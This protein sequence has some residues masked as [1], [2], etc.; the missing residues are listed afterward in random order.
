MLFRKK[1]KFYISIIISLAIL[2]SIVAIPWNYSFAEN[3]TE[4]L[5]EVM[6]NTVEVETITEELSVIMTPQLSLL[7][8]TTN[9]ITINWNYVPNTLAYEVEFNGEI[10]EEGVFTIYTQINLAPNIEY[11]FRVRGKNSNQVGDWSEL[12][13][14]TTLSEE[15]LQEDIEYEEKEVEPEEKEVELEEKEVEPEEKEVDIEEKEI[16]E[17]D[18][19]HEN[20]EKK[21]NSIETPNIDAN[22]QLT[23]QAMT[24]MMSGNGTVENPF[25]ITTRQELNDVRNNSTAHYRLGNDIDLENQLWTPIGTATATFK[26]SLDGAGYKITNLKTNLPTTDNVGLFGCIENATIKNLEIQNVDIIGRTRVG[27]LVGYSRGISNILNNKITGQ[28]LV[29]GVGT[30]GQVGGLIG[31]MEN[32]LVDKCFSTAAVE[33][34]GI[35]SADAEIGGLIGVL[36][37]AT[38]RESYSTGDVKSNR[39]KY[40][41]GLVGRILSTNV[42]GQLIENSFSLSNISSGNNQA[43]S[44]IGGLVGGIIR[45]TGFHVTIRNSYSAG[46][47]SY[48]TMHIG[49]G[50]LVGILGNTLVENSYYDGV[51]A[52]YIP[53]KVSDVGRLTTVMKSRDNYK[54]WDFNGIWTIDEGVSYPYLRGI[55]KPI[56]VIE[57]LPENDVAGGRGTLD[58]PYIIQTKEQLHNV[59]YEPT[60]HYVLGN[61][62]DLENELWQPVGNI[63]APFNGTFDGRGYKISNLKIDRGNTENI[64]F[65]GVI[66]NTV[67]Q[68]LEIQNVIVIGG[69]R[70]GALVGYAKGSNNILT[71]KITGIG[72]VKGQIAQAGGLIGSMENG[73]VNRSY[74]EA[75]VELTNVAVSAEIGG[76]IGRLTG[77]TIRESYASGNI[78]INRGHNAGGLI[79][80]ITSVNLAGQR[81][82]NSYSLGN[83]EIRDLVYSYY[84][85]GLIGSISRSTGY[86]VTIRNCY[87]SGIIFHSQVTAVGGIV[88]S[89]GNTI[90]ENSY[91]NGVSSRFIPDKASDV[92]RLTTAMKRRDNYN[93]WDF[94]SIW[95]IDE[96]MSYPY[97]RSLD[98]PIKVTEGLPENDV[99][100]GRGTLDNPYIIQTKEQLH[101][102]KYEPTGHYVLGN[103]IDLEN[104]LWQPVGNIGAPF[105]G[106]FDGRGYKIS[107]LKIDRGNTEN[108]G[109]FA[110]IENTVIKNLELN[111]VNVA[112]G[113][114]VGG[115]VGYSKGSNN[116]LDCKITGIGLVKGKIAQA[117]GLIGSMENGLV[118]RSYSEAAVELTNVSVT[119]EIGGLIGRLTGATIR[120]SYATGNVRI[121]IGQHAGGLIGNITSVN[122]AGQ[123]IENSYSLGNVQIDNL[124]ISYYIGGLVGSIS[125][126]A[127]YHVTI[128]NCYSA[129]RIDHNPVS[130][131]GGIVGSLGNTIME[132]SYYDGVST[133]FIPDKASDVARLTTTMKRRDNYNNWDFDSIWTIDEGMS[134]PYLRN[135]DKPIKVTEGLPI[136]DVAGGKG[137]LDNPYIIQT[138]GQLNSIKYEPTAHYVLGNDIDLENEVWHPIGNIGAPFKGTFDGRE[139]KVSNLRIERGS[140]DNTGFF[141]VIESSTVKNI[142]LENVNVTGGF[143]TGALVG[144]SKGTSN[145]LN[146]KVTG[147]GLIKG[148]G[149]KGQVGGLIGS[150]EKGQVYKS[151]STVS[152]E[153]IASS[154]VEVDIGGLIGAVAGATI[155]ESYS[156]GDVKINR[157]RYAGGL[158]GRIIQPDAVT[159]TLIE[160]S[161][162]LGDIYIQNSQPKSFFIGGL[163]GGGFPTIKNSYSAGRVTCDIET[164]RGGLIG[165]LG[166]STIENSYYDGILANYMPYY[167]TDIGRLTTAMTSRDNYTNWNFD[168]IWAIDEGASY[169]YL[170][171]LDKPTKVTEGLPE[172][173]VAGGRGT[174]D[175]PYILK[176]K[177]HLKNI[178]Y[179]PTAHYVLGNDIDLENELW[180]PIGNIGMPF[181][182]TFDGSGYKI[183]NLKIERGNVENIGLFAIIENAV[184]KNLEIEN[185]NVTGGTRVGGLVGY[186]RGSSNISN[187]KITGTSLI[188]AT[189]QTGQVGGLIGS[190]E[191]GLV[192]RSSSNAVVEATNVSTFAEIGGL[193]GTLT[194][195]T[196]RASYATGNVKSNRGRF[197]GGLIGT[198]NSVSIAG[199]RI[200]NCYALGNVQIGDSQIG[201]TFIG[202]LIGGITRSTG[203][204]VT[205]KNCYSSGTVA[206]SS[207]PSYIGGMVASLGNTVVEN[208]YFD[209][210]KTG[211]T[212]PLA[213]ARTTEELYQKQTFVGWD[214]D[215]I[216][217]IDEGAS[218]PYLDEI[219]LPPNLSTLQVSPNSI[220]LNWSRIEGVDGYQ[221]EVDGVVIDMVLDTTYTHQSLQ[222]GS[223]HEYRVRVIKN[224]VASDWSPKLV[225]ITP[226]PN[227]IVIT[228]TPSNNSILVEWNQFS[229]YTTY[230]I[231]LD[232]GTIVKVTGTSYTHTGLSANTQHYYRVRGIEPQPKSPWSGLATDIT[233]NG[234][235]SLAFAITD[236]PLDTGNEPVEVTI[237][238][239]GFEDIYTLHIDFIIR[240]LQFIDGT[241]EN[242]LET[243]EENGY[244]S[245]YQYQGAKM[246]V[247]I[248]LTGDVE[249]RQGEVDFMKMKLHM[250]KDPASISMISVKAVNSKGEYI[251]LSRIETLFINKIIENR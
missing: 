187:N 129:G 101:N 138:K 26:G 121:N 229:G 236:F 111:N 144:Y 141:G 44:N 58:N 113:T 221:L 98:K 143:R 59:K 2:I 74:S 216:W 238:G 145:V 194:G 132:N 225:V 175:N 20:L 83:V 243:D 179:E 79:G 251:E 170:K 71:T 30:T 116:I 35:T 242:L 127:G 207:N 63:G 205:I 168:S 210:T 208:S 206:F 152:V 97:L 70:V 82:E 51:S 118:N 23:I 232:G 135:L 10:V 120:E 196:I 198:I 203:Y 228:T 160:S 125:R 1:T 27:S 106:T 224:G 156:I 223:S 88:G 72:L 226:V 149:Q 193:I 60:A 13:R 184:I 249:G 166:N 62:I 213:Q 94:D 165:D 112:G 159:V 188:K 183:I 64:G 209:S 12:L 103:D 36:S 182:G 192:N 214:F 126:T 185:A 32:G 233:W 96:G 248:S 22:Q 115:L 68:N 250:L 119:A 197:A 91:Y 109:F 200:E 172:N 14:V 75:F 122:L 61:D 181:K 28:S 39:G 186:A 50:G 234:T 244:I 124:V 87:S 199:Q 15:S 201:G 46:R 24:M 40:V 43:G 17:V 114:R 57:G 16:E 235:P 104:E 215:N 86:H 195:A 230:E 110:I 29:K 163:V 90:M 246:K 155:R 89:L 190:M 217:R 5:Q 34:T 169:P 153:Y 178:K 7:E 117:G 84:I 173:D 227:D 53:D 8:V 38:I 222:A 150:M 67:I 102:V 25:I 162:S 69:T 41:A 92:A 93:N 130:S 245:T 147:I 99:A 231:E 76:L 148:I 6:E 220:T 239:N 131:I 164:V 3:N 128:R 81:I 137:T 161:F 139:Y 56:R 77:A 146:N 189:G 123:R 21:E 133:R 95:A 142:E 65:F 136:D 11:N 219:L 4:E 154:T 180:Q 218:Y 78:K 52:Q 85:G 151:Y 42:S 49:I 37:G 176:T 73:L 33:V 158:V 47:I 241:I 204:H 31:S 191:N 9:S 167:V 174:L 212:T 18:K 134:Y 107:N 54:N 247:M 140:N 177:E 157:G 80:N 48:G 202:G 105:K 100:G 45:S 19:E 55:E 171:S 240:D 211:I 108:V 237:K 66:E